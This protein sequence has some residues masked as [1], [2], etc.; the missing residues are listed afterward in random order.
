MKRWFSLILLNLSLYSGIGIGAD[1]QLAVTSLTVAPTIDGDAVE[2][3]KNWV[4]VA[5]KPAKENDKKNRTGNLDVQIQAGIL[6]DDFYLIT[7]W[8][9]TEPNTEYREWRWKGKK[10]KRG[11]KRD[12]M[13]AVRFEMGG[14]FNSCMIAD[15]N[16]EVDTWLWSAG[17]SNEKSYATDGN[18]LITMK[19]T[20]NA[21]EYQTPSGK[22]VYIIKS[23]DEGTPGFK[24]FKPGRK[25]T[26]VSMPSVQFLS[27][28]EGSIADVSAKGIWKD[29]YWTLEFKR[30]LNTGHK[31]DVE[32]PAKGS[33]RGQ[34]AVFNKGYAE[35]KSFSEFIQFDF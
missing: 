28:A 32:L 18:H 4:S 5:V 6:G 2:W 35:H 24:T 20:E 17:R 30:K 29:G 25:K 9:D 14:D 8:P 11:R 1:Q 19:Y 10:Y 16:Y 13:F 31:D 22:T 27:Q 34:V 21:A 12:D 23:S 7:R 26:E 15:A 33:I 3:S